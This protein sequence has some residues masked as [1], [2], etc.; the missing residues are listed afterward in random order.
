MNVAGQVQK[1]KDRLVVKGYSQVEGVDFGDI[2]SPVGK[3]TFIRLLM[4]LATTLDL[5]IE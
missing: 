5:E 4:Y 2:F 1:F 3:I